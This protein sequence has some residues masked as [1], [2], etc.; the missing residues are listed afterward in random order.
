M[1]TVVPESEYEAKRAAFAP[2]TCEHVYSVAP[3]KAKNLVPALVARDLH[4][5]NTTIAELHQTTPLSCA[6]AVLREGA[7]Q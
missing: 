2:L 5:H 4:T 3:R 7:G 6:A 1:V